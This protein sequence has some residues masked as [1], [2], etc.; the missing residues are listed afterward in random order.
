M[1]EVCLIYDIENVK[2][3]V[4]DQTP[5]RL[6]VFNNCRFTIF[7]QNNIAELPSEADAVIILNTPFTEIK[8]KTHK[9]LTFLVSQEATSDRYQWHKNSFHHFAEVYTQWTV[10]KKNIIPSH[11]FLT[12]YIDKNYDELL[13][14][15]INKKQRT[16]KVAYIGNKEAILSGQVKRNNF[17]EALN[18]AFSS[19]K[20]IAVDLIGKTYNNPIDNKFDCLNQYK[21]GL[22]IENTLV[23]HY[24]TEKL[25]DIF[26][27]G[28]LPFYIGPKNIVDYFSKE[29]I[30]Q[31]DYE[32]VENSIQII[33]QAIENN[34][35]EKRLESI[36]IARNKILHDYNL[37]YGFS[38]I[39]NN[40]FETMAL[41]KKVDIVFPKNYWDQKQTILQRIKNKLAKE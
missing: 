35:Y 32:S 25:S 13:S 15:N 27:A 18:Q 38:E 16:D 29:A 31:L 37:C 30:I 40:K 28:C 20:N 23:D 11:G 3:D 21:Y 33:E 7:N 36:N 12:W 4:L 8:I 34:E 5:N 39:I 2:P 10:N 6:G 14:V 22:A 24:W 26:L 19:H 9:E 1:I 17:V 41:R